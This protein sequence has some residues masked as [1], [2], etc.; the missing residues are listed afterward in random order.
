MNN[1][2][3]QCPVDNIIGVWKFSNPADH[4]NKCKSTPGHLIHFVKKGSYILTSNGRSYHIKP[5]DIIYYHGSEEVE[6]KNQ[7]ERV[8][9]YSVAFI[10]EG[11]APLP[12][13]RRKW[14]ANKYMS[15]A[16]DA[17]YKAHGL[18]TKTGRI[19]KLYSHLFNILD[20]IFR[21]ADSIS[22]KSVDNG[23]WQL[24]NIIREKKLYKPNTDDLIKISSLSYSSLYRASL[25]AVGK[26]PAERIQ[27][28]RMEEAKGLLLYSQWSI[29]EIAEALEY[30]TINEFSRAF[31]RFYKMAP[32]KFRSKESQ[33]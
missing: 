18:Y 22:N 6:W 17:I 7:G 4:F 15:S 23:W 25:Q 19:F 9:Y 30:S 13:E 11:L 29:T 28:I 32:S 10:A 26:S 8:E 27:E 12:M 31:S 2:S 1:F 3:N 16:F 24:E 21:E 14:Q 5:N 20:F 33:S